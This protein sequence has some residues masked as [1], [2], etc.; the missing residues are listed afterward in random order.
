MSNFLKSRNLFIA[1]LLIFLVTD[2]V[3]LAGVASNRSGEP[4]ARLS[5]TEREL[6]LP[7]RTHSENS[8]L[9]LTLVWRTLGE[10]EDSLASAY[11]PPAWFTTTKLKELGYSEAVTGPDTDTARRGDRPTKEVFIVLEYGGP[12]Y[13][14]ALHRAEAALAQAKLDQGRTKEQIAE[15]IKQAEARLVEERNS[16]SRLF[17]IDAGLNPT[18]LR[19]KYGEASRYAIVR[20]L[21]KPYYPGT[22][23]EESRGMIAGITIDTIA[24]PLDIRRELIKLVNLDHPTTDQAAMPRYA[25]DLAYGRRNEPWISAV[26][27]A[28][29]ID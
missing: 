22:D 9:S 24:V 19:Q 2:I 15:K 8:S 16:A 11:Q 17:A 7:Y 26:R 28:G 14:Q 3:I 23:D 21:V 5:L 12:A 4:E 10:S 20:G 18:D 13:Q 27:E 25:V 1:I 29:V 6:N